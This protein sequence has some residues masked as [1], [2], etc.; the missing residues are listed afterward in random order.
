MAKRRLSESFPFFILTQ[1]LGAFNDNFFKMLLQ[2]YVLSTL[3]AEQAEGIISLATF[4]FTLPFVIFG[5]WSGYIADK[6]AKTSVM[7][8]VKIVEIGV[9]LVGALAFYLG[10]VNLMLF[11]MISANISMGGK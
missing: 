5:P 9:M 11:V 10:N 4:L 6:Y 7:R 2:L 8:V 3:V 1:S